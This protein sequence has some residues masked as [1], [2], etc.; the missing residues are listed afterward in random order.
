M[1]TLQNKPTELDKEIERLEQTV[2]RMESRGQ[3]ET[4]HHQQLAGLKKKK[5]ETEGVKHD[6][7]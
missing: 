6:G 7:K 4:A 3:M 1:L 2:A 5:A